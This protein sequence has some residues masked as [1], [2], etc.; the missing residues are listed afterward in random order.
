M[1]IDDSEAMTIV[2]PSNEN[3][4]DKPLI[5]GMIELSA[6]PYP[7]RMAANK[8]INNPSESEIKIFL[9]HDSW[10]LLNVITPN[11]I[12]KLE[13]VNVAIFIRLKKFEFIISSITNSC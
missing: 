13:S 7:S 2:I 9:P 4:L 1:K 12:N 3:M 11:K 8:Q 6:K 5:N 10:F